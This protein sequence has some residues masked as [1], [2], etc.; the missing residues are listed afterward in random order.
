MDGGSAGRVAGWAVGT[1]GSGVPWAWLSWWGPLVSG[2][3][4]SGPGRMPAAS[5]RGEA[6]GFLIVFLYSEYV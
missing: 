5:N 1:A 2:S 6:E 3:R 4:A